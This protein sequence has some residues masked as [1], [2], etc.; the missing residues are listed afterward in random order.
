MHVRKLLDWRKLLIY[1]HRWLGIGITAMF[2]V[3][4][5]SGVVLLYYGHPQITMGERLLR[6]Q[7]LDFSTATLTPA[8]AAAKAGIKPYRVRLSMYHGRPV[9]RLT[10]R[11]IGN[12]TAVFA[13]TGDVL[14]REDVLLAEALFF[15]LLDGGPEQSKEERGCY[16]ERVLGNTHF[17]RFGVAVRLVETH[18]LSN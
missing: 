1:S 17:E 11:S 8:Q 7:P 12:W 5:L 4:T 15:Q 14:P 3:W 13:D 16:R 18:L 6:F 10:R 9:Y 2:L